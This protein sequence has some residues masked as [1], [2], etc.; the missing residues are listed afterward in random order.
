MKALNAMVASLDFCKGRYPALRFDFCEF[1]SRSSAPRRAQTSRSDS[2]PPTFLAPKCQNAA[3]EHPQK[4]ITMMSGSGDSEHANNDTTTAAPTGPLTTVDRRVVVVLP[5]P[6][7]S[8]SL[9]PSLERLHRLHGTSLLLSATT[10]LKL[11]ASTFATACTIFHRFYHQSSLSKHNVWSTA[12]ACIILASKTE[13]EPIGIRNVILVFAH[14]YRRRR[15]VMCQDPST[16][17]KNEAVV[18][19]S[20]ATTLSLSE[21]EEILRHVKP[22]SPLGP[23]YQEWLK[24]ATEM[25]HVLLR[26]LGFTLYWIPDSHPHKFILYFVKVL[27]IENEEFAQK[28]WNWCN[29]SCRLDLCVRYEPELIVCDTDCNDILLLI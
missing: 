7:E 16:I 8:L 20:K 18:A 6:D 27:E 26:Q 1:R 24:S 4:R 17:L 19:S 22:M 21:K 25:E 28:A 13:E 12:M 14:L 3:K 11:K 10:L 5:N 15:L 23:V 2:F 9:E 29:D